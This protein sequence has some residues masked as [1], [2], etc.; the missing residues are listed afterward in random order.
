MTP[1]LDRNKHKCTAT[2]TQRSHLISQRAAKVASRVEARA[3]VPCVP[4][5]RPL[6]ARVRHGRLVDRIANLFISF[7]YCVRIQ[8]NFENRYDDRFNQAG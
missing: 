5:L 1:T 2:F 4:G 3:A 6:R 8:F 7:H